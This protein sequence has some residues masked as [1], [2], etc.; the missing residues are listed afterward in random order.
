M[1]ITYINIKEN[2]SINTINLKI[3]GIQVRKFQKFKNN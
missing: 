1:H 3:L 2:I